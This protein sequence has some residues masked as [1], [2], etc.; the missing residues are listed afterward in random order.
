MNN[1]KNIIKWSPYIYFFIFFLIINNPANRVF[2]LVISLPII[3]QLFLQARYLDQVLGAFTFILS[4]WL[5]LAY[6]SDLNKI[7]VVTSHSRKFIAI[8]GI[9][10]IS[11][12]V[13]TLLLFRNALKRFDKQVEKHRVNQAGLL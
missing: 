5:M 11:N 1:L 13:M 9:I 8:G 3:I 12:F 4:L 2:V 10:V 7:S 6:A